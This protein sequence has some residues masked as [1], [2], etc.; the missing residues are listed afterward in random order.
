MADSRRSRRLADGAGQGDGG[1]GRLGSPAGQ[2][3]AEEEAQGEQV[4]RL[5]DVDPS[6][7][8]EKRLQL[9]GGHVGQGAPAEGGLGP[10]GGDGGVGQVEVQQLRPLADRQQDVGRLDVA[11]Q[12]GLRMGIGQGPGDHG[13]DPGDALGVG[14]AL[15]KASPAGRFGPVRRAVGRVLDQGRA[16][17]RG[18]PRAARRIDPADHLVQGQ[19][20]PVG[21]AQA[22]QAGLRVVGDREDR[23]DVLVVQPRLDGR[24]LAAVAGDLQRDLAIA[25]RLVE[26]EED[27]GRPPS[28]EDRAEV[29]AVEVLARIGESGR[30]GHPADGLAEHQV[31]AELR[32]ERIAPGVVP[33][34]ELLGVGGLAGVLAE[35]EFLVDQADDPVL[36]GPERGELGEVFGD[37]G[38]LPQGEPSAEV[39]LDQGG[40]DFDVLL[41]RDPGPGGVQGGFGSVLPEGRHG[42]DGRFEGVAR[43]PPGQPGRSGRGRRHG[44]PSAAADFQD[45]PR[46]LRNLWTLRTCQPM[47]S[48]ISSLE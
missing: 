42:R 6:R 29:E 3:F 28:A 48:A 5:A 8:F 35:A 18:P 45:S 33:G 21:H 40:E 17:D 2:E 43:A 12:D 30:L 24:F 26:G 44:R 27:A 9:L 37:R 10:V 20:G 19:P 25:E 7:G 4:G 38:A 15:G 22:P 39:G 1:V 11:V 32:F 14:P 23:H 47:R 46:S 41:G 31:V 16:K 34:A 36:G 13:D